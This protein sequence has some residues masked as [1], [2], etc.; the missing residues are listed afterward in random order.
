MC[1]IKLPATRDPLNLLHVYNQVV[2]HIGEEEKKP[3]HFNKDTTVLVIFLH[4]VIGSSSALKRETIYLLQ[5]KPVDNL[6][7]GLWRYG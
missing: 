5:L 7:L 3:G 1:F 4:F 2:C 6:P